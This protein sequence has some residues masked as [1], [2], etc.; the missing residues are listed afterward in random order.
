MGNTWRCFFVTE[1]KV[2]VLLNDLK[3]GR[4]GVWPGVGT[5][6][7]VELCWA[8]LPSRGR[9]LGVGTGSCAVGGKWLWSGKRGWLTEFAVYWERLGEA[10]RTELI[11]PRDRVIV[12]GGIEKGILQ[13]ITS[14]SMV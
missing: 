7:L 14:S 4:T 2:L 3:V 12:G 10:K 9:G 13:W 11:D 1:S 5:K 6:G 8:E